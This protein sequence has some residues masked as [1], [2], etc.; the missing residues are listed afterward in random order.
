MAQPN[1]R[2][3]KR[4]WQ[5]VAAILGA[6][7]ILAACGQETEESSDTNPD[8]VRRARAAKANPASVNCKRLGG[9]LTI[10]KRGDGG[11]YGICGFTNGGQCEEWAMLLGFCAPGGVDLAAYPT[12]AAKYCALRGGKYVPAAAEGQEHCVLPGGINCLADDLYSGECQAA[13]H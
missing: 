6:A 11:E 4:R 1:R 8:S 3:A 5:Q 13:E 10:E 12:P 7:L 9:N 2:D